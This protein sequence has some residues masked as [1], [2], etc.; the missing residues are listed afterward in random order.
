MGHSSS[1]KELGQIK[2]PRQCTPT[3]LSQAKRKDLYVFC[4]ASTMA[5]AVVAYLHTT[6]EDDKTNIRF[7]FGK[8]KL[9][10]HPEVTA[11]ITDE[12]D[13]M[14]DTV[15]FYSDSRVVLGYIQNESRMYVNNRV[16]HI[17]RSTTPQQ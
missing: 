6:D 15:T 10:P 11:I 17:R 12:M 14:F 2:L 4:D 9:A 3:S 5:T 8:A 13:S 1:L 16:Q 7:F